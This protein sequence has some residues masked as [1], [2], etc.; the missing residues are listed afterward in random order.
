MRHSTG[1]TSRFG[2]PHGPHGRHDRT[3]LFNRTA[4]FNRTAPFT[5]TV[6]FVSAALFVLLGTPMGTAGAATA[7]P[8]T[9]TVA[10]LGDSYSSGEGTPPFEAAFASCRRS[11]GA[12]PRLL[13]TLDP[14]A[15]N[16]LHA[17][18]GGATTE[19]MTKPQRGS[20]PQLEQL[21]ALPTPPDVVTLTIGGNDAGFSQVMFSCV[22]WKC[23]W[24]GDDRR[25]RDYVEDVLPDV[26][27]ATYKEVKAAAPHSRIVVV[28][29]PT[30]V[31]RSQSDNTCRWLDKSERR[32]LASL[33]NALNRTIRRAASDAGVEYVSTDR[34]LR[35]HEMCTKDSWVNPIG[36]FGASRSLSA[37]PTRAGQEALA[38][39]VHR[40]L[41]DDR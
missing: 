22:A 16:V 41:F 21:R 31:P 35:G 20:P 14:P 23:F 39:T 3:A 17:A 18:C 5:W 30:V 2:G 12:W 11:A 40:A 7:A 26:L 4:T 27:V 38:K 33:N 19:A 6:L 25:R 29:Y 15:T 13:A 8:G 34:S 28:G 37:H 10:A 24:D 36:L 32:Q 9:L 1:A